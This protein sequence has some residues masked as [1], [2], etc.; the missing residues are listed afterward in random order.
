MHSNLGDVSQQVVREPPVSRY[1]NPW[2]GV[3]GVAYYFNTI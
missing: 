1:E 3:G 2:L